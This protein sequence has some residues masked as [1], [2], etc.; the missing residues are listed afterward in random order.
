MTDKIVLLELFQPDQ[1]PMLEIGRSIRNNQPLKIVFKNDVPHLVITR[2]INGNPNTVV[3]EEAYQ[4]PKVMQKENSDF[5]LKYMYL[6]LQ[7]HHL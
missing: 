1:R 2:V 7:L 3:I 6:I 4:Y 5:H